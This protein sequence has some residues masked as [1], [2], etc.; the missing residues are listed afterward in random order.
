MQS[1]WS[2]FQN[3]KEFHWFSYILPQLSYAQFIGKKYQFFSIKRNFFDRF[4][5]FSNNLFAFMLI[6]QI[7]SI[8][9]VQK[10]PSVWYAWRIMITARTHYVCFPWHFFFKWFVIQSTRMLLYVPFKK[11]QI[12]STVCFE[13]IQY[14][15]SRFVPC[16]YK[17][18]LN[19]KQMKQKKPEAF[20]LRRWRYSQWHRRFGNCFSA[21]HQSYKTPSSNRAVCTRT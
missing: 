7:L 18:P 13:N 17:V 20:S 4:S 14:R 11:P 16:R 10:F 8:K 9:S 6:C 12:F 15:Y 3:G 19:L 2:T 1:K 5:H 21:I